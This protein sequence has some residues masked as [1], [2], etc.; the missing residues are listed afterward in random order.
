M[1]FKLGSMLKEIG[2][3]F[4]IILHQQYFYARFSVIVL[5]NL[6]SQKIAKNLWLI[7]HTVFIFYL[8]DLII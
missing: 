2:V 7:I 5:G 6:K 4:C 1:Y 8:E 3:Q